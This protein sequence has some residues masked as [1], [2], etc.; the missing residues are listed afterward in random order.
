MPVDEGPR[1]VLID[2]NALVHRS[3]R[4]ISIRGNL[5]VG[6][7][8]ED[9]T[10]VFGFTNTFLRAMQDYHPT[11]C[12]IT[13]DLPVPTFRHKM[14]AE[15]KAQRPPTPPELRSQFDRVRQLMQAFRVAIFEI[16]GYEADD[17]LGTLSLQAQEQEIPTI[18]LTGDTDTLQLV[19]PWVKVAIHSGVQDKRVYDEA[20][21]K[22]RFYGLAAEQQPD[23]KALKGDSSDNIPG[24]PGIGDKTAA[25]L[26]LEYGTLEGVYANVEGRHSSEDPSSLGEPSRGSPAGQDPHHHRPGRARHPRHGPSPLLDLLPPGRGRLHARA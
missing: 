15:Y 3:F 6:S 14:F 13:F 4:A 24:V 16:E 9:I 26:L 12:A 11:H 23:F 2:G 20:E 17:V 8:G 25:R 7:T 5:T 1:L 21:V 18:I 22:A 10:G 19:S